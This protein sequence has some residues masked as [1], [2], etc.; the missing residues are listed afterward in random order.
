MLCFITSNKFM[1]AKYGQPLRAF[2]S[3][4][5]P[6]VLLLDLAQTGIFGATVRPLI[7]LSQ[8][9]GARGAL[10]AAV[11]RSEDAPQN[12]GAFMRENGFD[13]RVSD[14]RDDGWTLAEPDK[15][16][17]LLDRIRAVG[18]PL[19]D[20]LSEGLLSWH[21]DWFER[22]FRHRRRHALAIDRRGPEQRPADKAVVARQGR[23]ALARQLEWLIC[24]FHAPRNGHRA[25]S[26]PSN[27]I[28]HNF[29]KIWNRSPC[30]AVSN[31]GENRAA[32]N[33]SISKTTSH[34]MQR[35]INQKLFIRILLKEM[36]AFIDREELLD[37]QQMLYHSEGRFLSPCLIELETPRLLFSQA[38]TVLWTIR[39]TEGTWNSEAFFME[40]TSIAPAKPDIAKSL[41]RLANEI[42]S[43]KEADPNAD[44]ARLERQIDEMVY[45]L[46]GLDG[47]DIC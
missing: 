34:T 40:R 35:S 17:H 33:G 26:Q 25:V 16:L 7:M 9:G 43:E 38:F 44:V 28:C 14:L 3:A 32:I 11:V 20:Y 27:G 36:G 22:G 29:A 46:Y 15:L 18:K 41:S 13:M 45:S 37:K 23:A 8:K 31:E 19:R 5:A 10:R 4:D 47:K 30:V 24:D 6:P 2:L 1:R 12:L 21:H 39:S 42:Q